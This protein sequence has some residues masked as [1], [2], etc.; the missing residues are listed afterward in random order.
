MSRIKIDL[1]ET[2]SFSTQIPVRV[3]DLNYGN[4]VGNDA[5]LTMLHEGRLQFLKSFGYSELDLEGAGL[6]MADVGIEYKG[7]GFY[8]DV[9]TMHIAASGF[10][11][12][13][14]DLYY[15]LVNQNNKEIA[16]AKTGMLCMDYSV[17]KLT[18]LPEKAAMRLETKA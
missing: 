9:F 6:I 16:K 13:G 4:H 5:I 7:E 2:F 17:R 18:R 14:F 12:F 8:G 10:H 3:S 15:H 11:K 1:P